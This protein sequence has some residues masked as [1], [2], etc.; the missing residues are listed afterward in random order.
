VLYFKGDPEY[1]LLFSFLSGIFSSIFAAGRSA[2]SPTLSSDTYKLGGLQIACLLV[3]MGFGAIF[4]LIT[5]GVLKLTKG[6]KDTEIGQD[7]AFWIINHDM[8]PLYSSDKHVASIDGRHE[9]TLPRD[10]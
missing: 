10:M 7:Q 5:A 2:R 6:I 3:S 1:I 4:G 8:V 9:N